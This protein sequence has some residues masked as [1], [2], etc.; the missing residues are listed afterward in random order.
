MIKHPNIMTPVQTMRWAM[1]NKPISPRENEIL[2]FAEKLEQK[3]KD[4]QDQYE[5]IQLRIVAQKQELDM[6]LKVVEKERDELRQQKVDN[7]V[8]PIQQGQPIPWHVAEIAYRHYAKA[9]GTDQSMNRLAERGGFGWTEFLHLYFD[10]ARFNLTDEIV[11]KRWADDRYGSVSHQLQQATQDR[12]QLKGLAEKMFKALQ[13]LWD[14]D[15]MGWIIGNGR[16]EC[17]KCGAGTNNALP[18][19][20]QDGCI[21]G[22]IY[23]A[24]ALAKAAGIGKNENS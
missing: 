18:I 7:K 9:Y 23:K 14:D 21:Q 19:V 6:K 8:F 1:G 11:K 2:E 15:E 20:H 3:L 10:D 13:I 16:T 4:S 17:V 24:L 22:Y 5:I 12:D